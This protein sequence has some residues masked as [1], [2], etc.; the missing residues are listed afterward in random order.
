MDA[1]SGTVL[2]GMVECTVSTEQVEFGGKK[3]G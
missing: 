2:L 1:M 3:T